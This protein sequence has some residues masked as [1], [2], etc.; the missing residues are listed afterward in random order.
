MFVGIL[1][2]SLVIKLL[3]KAAWKGLKLGFKKIFAGKGGKKAD[4]VKENKEGDTTIPTE[5]SVASSKEIVNDIKE[6]KE[7]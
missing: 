5:N 1:I 6:V 2:I 3:C 4:V 7:I